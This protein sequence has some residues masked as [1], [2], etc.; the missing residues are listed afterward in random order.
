MHA[1]IISNEEHLRFEL[2]TLVMIMFQKP[3]NWCCRESKE[4][5]SVSTKFPLF[6]HAHEFYFY[7]ITKYMLSIEIIATSFPGSLIFPQQ[8]EKM[9]NPGNESFFVSNDSYHVAL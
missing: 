8:D 2:K 1:E 9:K 7:F 6:R 3:K 5:V 4:T